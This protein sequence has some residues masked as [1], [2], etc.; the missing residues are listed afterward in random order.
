MQVKVC[1]V[2]RPQDA[3]LACELGAWAIGMIL[4]KRGPRFVELERAKKIR[5]A[6][7]EDAF[8]VGVFVNETAETINQLA[9]ALDLDLVQLHGE[10]TPELLATLEVPAV[11]AFRVV[12]ALPD[13]FPWRSSWATLLEGK[14]RGESFDWNLAKGLDVPS[15]RLILAGALTPENVAEAV[16]IVDPFAVDVAS[17]IESK[18]GEKDPKKMKAFFEALA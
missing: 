13:F 4:S 2:T 12:G 3:A 5:A 9:S 15:S 10:E 17:G 1:G 18:P 6:M 14:E 11:K 7:P 16:A 8:A